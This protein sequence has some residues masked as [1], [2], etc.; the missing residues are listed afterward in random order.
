MT[1][2]ML[3]REPPAK[4][5]RVAA[6]DSPKTS[7]TSLPDV[8]LQNIVA[9][10]PRAAK[11][12]GKC[13]TCHRA[14]VGGS[15]QIMNCA[16][17][18]APTCPVC[19]RTCTAVP[20]TREP[21]P[22]LSFSSSTSPPTPTPSPRRAA[23]SLTTNTNTNLLHEATTTAARRRK[24]EDDSSDTALSK[25]PDAEGWTQGCGRVVCR[26]CSVESI[27]SCTITC[28]DCLLKAHSASSDMD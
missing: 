23:L 1:S 4:R 16:R 26:A 14:F 13:S 2:R 9:P 20:P 21:T 27:Q 22:A 3:P 19:T 11:K 24:H 10:T 28:R 15:A 12:A 5:R 6:A 17:C 7:S 8:G 18:D 25:E